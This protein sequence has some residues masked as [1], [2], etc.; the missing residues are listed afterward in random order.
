MCVT[1]EYRDRPKN[2]ITFAVAA[3]VELAEYCERA[4]V[5]LD[6]SR[7]CTVSIGDTLHDVAQALESA[8]ARHGKDHSPRPDCSRE[9]GESPESAASS[10]F[11]SRVLAY[12][13]NFTN[14][15]SGRDYTP[16][17]SNQ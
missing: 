1:R 16:S 8:D 6:R 2:R 12:R 15:H 5:Y 17:D 11:P 3:G 9:N 7:C 4:V 14:W 10:C 13:D